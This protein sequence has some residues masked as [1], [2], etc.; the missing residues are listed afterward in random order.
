[1]TRRYEILDILSQDHT[2]VA[3]HAH[4]RETDRE[5][6]VRRFFPFGPDG[7]GLAQEESSAYEI[8]VRRLREVSHPSLRSVVDGGVD[9][10]DHIPFLVT[11][12]VEGE[13]LALRLADGPVS[14]ESV[15]NL[16][17]IALE[18]SLA[19]SEIFGE[20]AIWV[21]TDPAS[22]V[23]S[24]DNPERPVT[25]WIS[26]LRWLSSESIRS[27]LKPLL[28][29]VEKVSGWNGQVISRNSGN[30]LG[31]W[32]QTLRDQPDAWSLAQAREAL[33]EPATL[34]EEMAAAAPQTEPHSTPAPQPYVI[35]SRPVVWPW[36][37]AASLAFGAAG[38]LAWRHFN[39]PEVTPPIVVEA[40][41]SATSNDEPSA[42][43]VKEVVKVTDVATR[44][45][46]AEEDRIAR[47]NQ[48]ARDMAEEAEGAPVITLGETATKYGKIIR[49]E[50]S[51]SGK[52]HYF[53]FEET[54]TR[55][56]LWASFRTA[57]W[58]DF[59]PETLPEMVGKEARFVGEW[60]AE[61]S[62]RKSVL[63][64]SSESQFM[65]LD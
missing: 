45:P 31:A 6:V 4:D 7:G 56:R 23:I 12:W 39:P 62:D 26:P 43:P 29:M 40:G 47:I 52:T 27:D 10:D 20:E 22:V 64:M 17:D 51:R 61:R 24:Q 38:I 3:F 46:T 35:A 55:H 8:G 54:N 5:V 63:Q 19:L 34:V 30:G 36:I 18:T 13:A 42:A 21:D 37:L 58:T 11:E 14:P 48:L 16:A 33:H 25:F 2:G 60:K 1:M 53:Q 59:D 32:V 50:A 9:P 65:L 41:E 44:T 49:T 15:R 28:D 57:D